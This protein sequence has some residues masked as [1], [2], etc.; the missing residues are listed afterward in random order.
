MSDSKSDGPQFDPSQIVE[1]PTSLRGILYRLGPGLIVA[2]SIVGS[3]ELIAT[4]ATGAEAGFLLL[5]LILI[6]CVIKVFVQVELGRFTITSGRTAMDGLN[7]VPGP[8]AGKANWLV[9][10]W[11]I[12]FLASL[13]Q[14]GGIAGGVGQALAISVPLTGHGRMYKEYADEKT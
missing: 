9:W 10:F 3:G 11:F 2:G 14:L 5:W 1:P 7:S 6:G 8:R 13:A 4:T 12:M